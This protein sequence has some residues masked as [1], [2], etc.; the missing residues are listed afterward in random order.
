MCRTA[1][2]GSFICVV[3]LQMQGV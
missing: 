3:T 1:M 2:Y